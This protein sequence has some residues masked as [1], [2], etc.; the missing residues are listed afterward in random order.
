MSYDDVRPEPDEIEDP[1]FEEALRAR[2]RR[3]LLALGAAGAAALVVLAIPWSES[4][5]ASGRVAPHR[6]ARVRSEAP[7]V[8]REVRRRSGE[9]VQQGEVLAVLDADAQRD[10]LEGTRL[11]LTRERQKLADLELRLRENQ[12]LREGAEAA[13]REAE[14][15]A[16]AGTKVEDARFAALEPAA[17]AVLERVRGFT[18]DARGLLAVDRT[19]RAA[20]PERG[21]E[22]RRAAEAAMAGYVDRAEAAAEHLGDVAG[23]DAGRELRDGLESVRFGYSLADRSMQEILLKR[24][25]VMQELLAP[26]ALRELISQLERESLELSRSF[27]ALASAARGLAGSPAERRERVRAADESR[28]LLANEAARLE[29]ERRAVESGIAQA[30]LAV[31]A[32]ERHQDATAIRAPIGGRLSGAGLA[33]FDGVA[34]NGAV[35]VVEDAGRLVLKVQVPEADWH[36]VE[37]GQ[38]VTAEVRGRSLRGEVAWKVPLAGQEVRDQEWNVLVDLHGDADGAEPGAKATATLDVGRRSLLRRLLG[39]A[40]SGPAAEPRVAF[41]D[42]PTEQRAPGALRELAVTGPATEAAKVS[43]DG[44]AGGAERAGGS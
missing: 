22:M 11:A 2:R 10:A 28:Q 23:E 7:G 6:W 3:L 21:A 5:D 8:V 25:L 32:A 29:A 33:E 12:I 38:E 39:G 36:R 31:R 1:E 15:R 14:R 30:E 44:A 40:G 19:E 37:P 18:I 27:R 13:V 42:D 17:A 16:F 20:R 43:A 9:V 34:A 41:V 35:G 26:V 24:E 4:V